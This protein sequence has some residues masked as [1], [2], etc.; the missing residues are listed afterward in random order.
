MSDIKLVLTDLDGTVVLPEAQSA[1][2]VVV[3]SIRE[4]RS[5]GIEFAAITGR[6]YWMAKDLL[7][8]LGFDGLCVLEGGG[9]IL[10]PQTGEIVWSKTV[11]IDITQ[12][13]VT[14]L[15]K[16]AFIMEY[17]DGVKAADEVQIADIKQPAFSI[18]ASVSVDASD[19]L[20]KTLQ[21]LPN[22]A[23]H[24]NHAPAGDT[25]RTGIQITHIEADKEHAVKKLLKI[26]RI[27]KAH[28]LAIGDG[29]NDLP[30][31]NAAE[32]KVAMGNASE[33]LKT[34]AD[35]IVPSV[36]DDGFAEAIQTYAV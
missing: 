31:F 32:V 13:I 4:A 27:D 26:V 14:E 10:N 22:I 24:A 5:R 28:T 11:P 3:S 16:H 35:Y 34:A 15:K 36:Q 9:V 25:T 8:H 30:L 2:D 19:E 23:V 6:P 29:N 12:T 18:W 1:S 21:K 7:K 33:L 20:V 17:G